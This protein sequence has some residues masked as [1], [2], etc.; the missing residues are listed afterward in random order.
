[1]QTLQKKNPNFTYLKKEQTWVDL[2]E[3]VWLD[4]SHISFEGG[5]KIIEN[6]SR[7]IPLD[8]QCSIRQSGNKT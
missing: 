1:M 8:Y 5:E 3:E 6:L 2:P 4:G 7:I